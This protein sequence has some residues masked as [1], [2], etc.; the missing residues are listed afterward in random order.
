MN[1]IERLERLGR[2]EGIIGSLSRQRDVYTVPEE[3]DCPLIIVLG[4]AKE[5]TASRPIEAIHVGWNFQ[6]I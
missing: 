3:L 2:S 6:E 1:R 5:G 4:F